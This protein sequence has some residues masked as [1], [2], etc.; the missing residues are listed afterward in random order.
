MTPLPSESIL[1]R[2]VSVPAGSDQRLYQFYQRRHIN[3]WRADCHLCA[4]DR[5]EHPASDEQQNAGR[6]PH[7]YE[8]AVRS[9]GNVVNNNL[10]SKPRMPRIVDFQLLPD[11]G[12]MNGQS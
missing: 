5:V 3:A 7:L 9:P 12:R 11:V 1:A 2:E 8:L 6:I 10:A 4:R